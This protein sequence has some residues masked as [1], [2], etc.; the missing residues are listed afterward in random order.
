MRRKYSGQK[1]L[2]SE[3]NVTTPGLPTRS[4]TL[5]TRSARAK[6][7][8]KSSSWPCSRPNYHPCTPSP[9]AQSARIIDTH[10]PGEKV[11]RAG[12]PLNVNTLKSIAISPAVFDE[13]VAMVKN[14]IKKLNGERIG[15]E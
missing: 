11:C 3:Q 9:R 12:G 14:K 15:A 5:E 8:K 13:L 1:S 7:R 4:D 2:R 10:G 6:K